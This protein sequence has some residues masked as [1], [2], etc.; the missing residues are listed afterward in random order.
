MNLNEV[1]E[2]SQ[3]YEICDAHAHIFPDKIARKAVESIN[4]FYGLE[5]NCPVGNPASLLKSGRKI[6]IS[7]YLV[8]STA[9]VP[10]QVVSINN[11]IMEQCKAHPEFMGLGTLHPDFPHIEK[12]VQRC[13]DGGLKGIKLHPDFQSFYIDGD[14]AYG[15]YEK[16]KG[17]LPVLMHMGDSRFDFSHPARLEKVLK[18]LPELTVIAAHL[19]GYERWDEAIACL[20]YPNVRFDSSSSLEFMSA[21][22]ARDLIHGFGAE[23][24]FFGTDFPMSAHAEEI[25]RF[26]K[27][28]LSDKE[29]KLILGE[30]FKRE[31]SIK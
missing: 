5:S 16:I 18:A 15:I 24:I 14:K 25:D 23:K 1:L 3:Q 2:F 11:F 26:M 17:R 12:E 30:N 8:C 29:N 27:L 4:S 20:Y 19:G 9:T 13:I 28:K 6:G 22:F 31:F 7:R 21:E 10:E